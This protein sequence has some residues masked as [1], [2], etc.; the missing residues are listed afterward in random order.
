MPGFAHRPPRP[1]PAL[2]ARLRAERKFRNR[3][4]APRLQALPWLDAGGAPVSIAS[5]CTAAADA[6]LNH[7]MQ[8]RSSC[9][10]GVHKQLW[11]SLKHAST[12]PHAKRLCLAEKPARVTPSALPQAGSTDGQLCHCTCITYATSCRGPCLAQKASAEQRECTVPGVP[13]MLAP[14]ACRRKGPARP[15]RQHR[16]SRCTP[17]RGC[18]RH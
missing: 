7:F 6:R 10:Y 2:P 18:R 14:A 13:D 15:R 1:A 17:H 8:I 3:P 16:C 4:P 12:P 11:H 9:D 5:A